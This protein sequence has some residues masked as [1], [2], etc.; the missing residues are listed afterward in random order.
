MER[1]EKGWILAKKLTWIYL[2]VMGGLFPLFYQNGFFNILVSKYAFFAIATGIYAVIMIIFYITCVRDREYR[3]RLFHLSAADKWMLFF[4]F[5]CVMSQV[6]TNYKEKAWLGTEGRYNGLQAML[7]YG[8]V[9]FMVSRGYCRSRILGWIFFAGG[10]LVNLLAVLNHFKIDPLNIQLILSKEQQSM[11]ISTVGNINIFSGFASMYVSM[12]FAVFC[13]GKKKSTKIGGMFGIIIGMSGL[14]AGNSDSGFL[15]LVAV[16]GFFLVLFHI[17]KRF[18]REWVYGIILILASSGMMGLFQMIAKD[19][20]I[21][22][23]GGFA[24]MFANEKFLIVAILLTVCY[25]LTLKC[26][27]F[28][29]E[30]HFSKKKLLIIVL[31][32]MAVCGAIVA[33]V[34]RKEI[35]I[36][37]RQGD[38]FHFDDSWGTYRGFIWKRSFWIFLDLPLIQK[39]FGCGLDTLRTMMNLFY[40][41][42]MIDIAGKIYDNAHNEY[43]QY[44]VTTGIAGLTAYAG[45]LVQ[46]VCTAVKRSKIEPFFLILFAGTFAYMIQSV[47]NISQS[48]ITFF[49]FLWVALIEGERRRENLY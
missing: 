32:V 16:C 30:K 20:A 15:G 34:N 5:C 47:V 1:K 19:R 36:F 33:W 25:P 29:R 13:T 3:R 2:A 7:L 12:A 39:I 49:L 24:Q 9:Y 31:C 45:L 42:D 22:Y 41:Q 37:F 17:Q 48:I 44:L 46:S 10:G 8:L 26:M 6:F 11:F 23:K 28:L 35:G 18:L 27:R 40:R 43:L 4:L 21:A 14:I 38:F